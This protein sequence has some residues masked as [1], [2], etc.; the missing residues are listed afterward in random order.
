MLLVGT[1]AAAEQ[2]AGTPHA[3]KP[4]AEK[5][6]ILIGT[7]PDGHPEGTHHY[8]RECRLLADCL[9]QTPGVQ[10]MVSE[11]WP[12][13]PELLRGIDAMVLY[14]SPGAEIVLDDSHAERF[15]KLMREGVGLV[16]LH[17]ATG[18]GDQ[19]NKTLGKRYQ[20]YL[21]GL[22]SFAYS[23]L[24]ISESEIQQ[25]APDH[26]ICRGWEP[27][28]LKDEFYLNL[29]FLPEAKPVL[30]VSVK[31]QKQTVAWVYERPE[32]DGGRSY[33]NTLGHFHELFEQEA[34]RRMFVNG[35]LWTMHVQIPEAGSPGGQ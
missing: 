33:G 35:I 29:K 8:L 15:E 20:Q 24:D 30:Q 1:V 28:R 22:F 16:A 5:K 32:S 26:P 25:V 34:F 21:G 6:V 31:G 11:G 2:D 10:A 7:Q 23:G 17:W 18:V 19:G 14:S 3:G 4:P 27:F 12:S 13:D 9:R